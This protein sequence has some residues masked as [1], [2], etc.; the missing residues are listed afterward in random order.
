V[1]V[2]RR[3]Q[4]FA[5]LLADVARFARHSPGDRWFLDETYVKVNGVW[6]YVCRVLDQHGQVIDVLVSSRRDAA[7]CQ[8]RR[9]E[10]VPSSGCATVL[11]A[12]AEAPAGRECCPAEPRSSGSHRAVAAEDSACI[13][14][15]MGA[16]GC[17]DLL[18]QCPYAMNYTS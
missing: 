17:M 8:A 9:N 3:V 7:S 12:T 11:S 13:D 2:Y 6:H 4:R 14:A 15:R 18:G 1:T 16:L 10:S 5:P